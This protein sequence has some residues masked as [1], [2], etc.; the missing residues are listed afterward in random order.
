M[1]G[2]ERAEKFW[3]AL[4]EA[5]L[6]GRPQMNH[7]FQ[8]NCREGIFAHPRHGTVPCAMAARDIRQVR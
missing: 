4:F 8:P 5:I 1:P 7:S 2:E 3:S 6:T